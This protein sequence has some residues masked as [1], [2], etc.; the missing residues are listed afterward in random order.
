MEEELGYKGILTGKGQLGPFPMERMKRVEPPTTQITDNVQRFDQRE[1]GFF[2][3]ARGDF[4]P[5]VTRERHRPTKY[6]ILAAEMEMT[7]YLAAVEE[8]EVASSKAPIAEEPR[9]L[10]RHIK[11]L[12]YFL[13]ADIVGICRLPQYAVYSPDKD[14]NPLEL[15]HQ[16]AIVV[17][18]DQDYET[19]NASTGSDWISASQSYRSYSATAFISQIL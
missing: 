5:T 16:F 13:R 18:V 17:L 8:G 6:P 1:Q 15:N 2:R 11:R 14:G 7:H 12:G 3:A 19:M 9:L 10:N 4:G